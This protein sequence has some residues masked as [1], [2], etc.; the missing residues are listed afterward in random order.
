MKILFIEDHPSIG[1]F[2]QMTMMDGLDAQ[3]DLVT[4]RSAFFKL[5]DKVH[6][7]DVI[8]CDHYFPSFEDS[9]SPEE[10]GNHIFM[11]LFH[12][13]YSGKFIHFSSEP[14]PEKYDLKDEVGTKINFHSMQK[15]ED[16]YTAT[17]LNK[18]IKES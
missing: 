7:Y 5:I 13:N 8:V 12:D 11:E 4:T 16:G 1:K 15:K 14:C 18:L 6:D 2:F 17:Q 3:V 9:R 10:N